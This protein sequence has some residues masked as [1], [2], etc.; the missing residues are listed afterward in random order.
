M[1]GALGVGLVTGGVL[2]VAGSSIGRPAQSDQT[3]ATTGTT[4]TTGTTTG[5]PTTSTTR[6][7]VY[8]VNDDGRLDFA[9]ID[10]EVVAVPADPSDPPGESHLAEWLVFAGTVIAAIIGAGGLVGVA[11]LNR[12]SEDEIVELKHRIDALEPDPPPEPGVTADG[13]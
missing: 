12:D 10:G 1:A 9:V 11:R 7:R 8:D 6:V 3:T 13:R 2:L 4:D 5:D